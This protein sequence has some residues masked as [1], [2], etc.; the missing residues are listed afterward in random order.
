VREVVLAAAVALGLGTG[1]VACA[2]SAPKVTPVHATWAS[3][4]WPGTTS[5]DLERGRTVFVAKCSGCHLPPAP[6]SLTPAQWPAQIAEM[7]ERA[8]LVADERT[9]IERYVIAVAS[10]K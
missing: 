6:D 7:S 8:N 5:A 3:A 2:P 4:Q 10:A 9:L 1:L